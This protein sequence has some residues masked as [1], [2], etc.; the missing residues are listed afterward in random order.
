MFID[1]ITSEK[2]EVDIAIESNFGSH[3]IIISIECVVFDEDKKK[4]N[5]FR[6]GF[7]V[8]AKVEH[9]DLETKSVLYQGVVSTLAIGDFEDKKVEIFIE[10]KENEEPIVLSD[11][12]K[13]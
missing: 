12:V 4:Y 7:G 11:I 6:I 9:T 1:S 8:K 5:V 2:R 3:S 10:E 13:K